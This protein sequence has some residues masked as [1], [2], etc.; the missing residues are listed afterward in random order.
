[1][2]TGL[3]HD[4]ALMYLHAARQ[5]L[6]RDVALEMEE[7]HKHVQVDADVGLF[8]AKVVE[9]LQ[10]QQQQQQQKGKTN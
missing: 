8:A 6:S 1:L 3:G 9:K 7:A 2:L 10:Q 5:R 4:V